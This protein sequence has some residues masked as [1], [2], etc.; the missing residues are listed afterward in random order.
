MKE[1]YKRDLQKRPAKETSVKW[2]TK[3]TY[4][5]THN[6]DLSKE[7]YTTQ[8]NRPTKETYDF[9]TYGYHTRALPTTCNTLQHTAT[10]T[11]RIWRNADTFI[12]NPWLTYKWLIHMYDKTH[13]YANPFFTC[14]YMPECRCSSNLVLNWNT[15]RTKSKP[16]QIKRKQTRRKDPRTFCTQSSHW[17]FWGY[18]NWGNTF[19][20]LFPSRL[21][22]RKDPRTFCTQS[23]HLSPAEYHGLREPEVGGWGRDPKKCTGRGWGMGSSTI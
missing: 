15:L 7:T 4:K 18:F 8:L 10:H 20:S 12:C 19:A 6:R 23:S 11:W 2:P 9:C 5:R 1:T 21:S 22:L 14:A 16:K 13:S 17:G 3:E